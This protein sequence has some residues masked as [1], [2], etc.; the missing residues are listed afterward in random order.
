M[1]LQCI[2]KAKLISKKPILPGFYLVQG[3]VGCSEWPKGY[4]GLVE[5]NDPAF[6]WK[7][8]MVPEPRKLNDKEKWL[9]MVESIEDQFLCSGNDILEFYRLVKACKEKGYDEKKH[10]YSVMGWIVNYI[11]KKLIKK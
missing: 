6:I 11:G 7:E 3:T 1:C 8:K 2:T 4:Y 9:D 5:Y 10:G